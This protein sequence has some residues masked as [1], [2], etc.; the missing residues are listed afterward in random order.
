MI[1]AIQIGSLLLFVFLAAG[2]KTLSSFFSSTDATAEPTYG[3]DAPSNMKLGQEALENKNFLEAEK[4]FDYV[5]S[6]YPYIEAS[7]E[8]ELRLAD[9]TFEEEKYPEARDRYEGF[10]KLHPTHPKVDYAAYRAAYTHYKEIPSDFFLLPPSEEKD[11]VEVN[12]TVKAMNEFLRQYPNSKYAPEAKKTLD[13]ARKRLA[14]HELYV[15]DFYARRKRWGAVVGRLNT[16]AEKYQ[17]LGLDERAL[18]GMYDAYLK[19]KDPQ[20]AQE[21]LRKVISRLP[22]TPA[23]QRAAKLLGS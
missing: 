9:A 23:A 17:G 15:A 5:R 19:L 22:G 12:G 20:R 4:Y 13:D 21:T 14:Q 16:V 2:C 3:A 8:A 1:K 10:V 7:K 18:F 6:K 11:Q